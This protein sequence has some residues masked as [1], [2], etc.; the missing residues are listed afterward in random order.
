MSLTHKKAWAVVKMSLLMSHGLATV[1][2]GFFIN[3]E[4][5]VENQQVQSLVAR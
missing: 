5:I 2:R 3:E 1:E 4:I